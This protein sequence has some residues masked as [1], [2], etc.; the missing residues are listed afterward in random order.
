MLIHIRRTSIVFSLLL[1]INPGTG[2]YL[3][4]YQFFPVLNDRFVPIVRVF[5]DCSISI[6]D[7]NRIGITKQKYH[8]LVCHRLASGNRSYKHQKT[9]DTEGQRDVD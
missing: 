7:L 6:C 3:F 8:L 1:L 5:N 4:E 2:L 9:I